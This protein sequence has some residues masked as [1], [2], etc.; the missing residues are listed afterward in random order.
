MGDEETHTRIQQYELAFRMQASVPELTDIKSEP[1][2]TYGLYGEEARKPGTFA[3]SVLMARRMVE[4]GVRFVQI[5][6]NNWDTH[7]MWRADCP[8]SARTWISRAGA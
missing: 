8:A 1:E 6:H 5:Y 4:R 7:G 3:N 2:N